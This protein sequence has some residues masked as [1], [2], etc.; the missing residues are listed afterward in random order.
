MP[1]PIDRLTK[2]LVAAAATGISTSQ[3]PITAG[4]KF[5]LNGSKV[6]GGVAT[7]DSQR[8]VIITSAG[9]DSGITFTITG[10]NDDGNT[11]SEVLTGANATAAVS[12]L[13]YLTVTSIVANGTT[14]STVTAGTNTTG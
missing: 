12:G 11:I 14:A 7:F 9:N 8:R 2:S 10:T 13:D 5:T 3:G 6:S 1:N 4:N